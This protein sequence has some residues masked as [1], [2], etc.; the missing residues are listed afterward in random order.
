LAPSGWFGGV[1][2]GRVIQEVVMLKAGKLSALVVAVTITV[3]A[4]APRTPTQT[5]NVVIQW[6]QT[7]QTLFVGT[8]PGIH[9]R[10]LPM[11]HIAMFDAINS[12]EDVYTPYLVQ[13]KS[14]RG[15]SAEAAAATAAR[16]V[17]TA[18]YP[19]QQALFDS[20][21]ATQ[22]AG[23]PRGLVRQGQAV[24]HAVAA[25]VL[26]WRENDGWPLT[27]AAVT[28]P[29]PNYVLPTFPGLW[30]PTPPANSLATFTFYPNVVPLR[31]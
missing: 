9:I 5:P 8:G 17:L 2:S 13:A 20:A 16:D 30:Q 26:K 1:L 3:L 22:L 12:I 14:S 23:M 19:A 29:D 24:G 15:G 4:F 18:I 31:C 10:A 21:L 7:L 6:N 11:M 28:T 27:Q 25:A